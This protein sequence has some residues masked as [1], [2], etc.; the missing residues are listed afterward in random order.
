MEEGIVLLIWRLR[1][2]DE[3]G[4]EGWFMG[5]GVLGGKVFFSYIYPLPF[6]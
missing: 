4:K 3:V 1:L 2:G 6:F 5:Y